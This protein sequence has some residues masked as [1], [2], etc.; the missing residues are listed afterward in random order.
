MKQAE[1][2]P[3]K[4]SVD[5]T[6]NNTAINTSEEINK[7]VADEPEPEIEEIINSSPIT[8]NIQADSTQTNEQV[9]TATTTQQQRQLTDEEKLDAFNWDDM[10]GFFSS[11]NDTKVQTAQANNNDN[12]GISG[13]AASS[14]NNTAS[15]GAQ[16]YSGGGKPTSTTSDTSDL[17]D[18]LNNM[19]QNAAAGGG[20]GS[21][22]G[23]GSN[24]SSEQTNNVTGSVD[25]I[26]WTAAGK[27]RKLLTPEKPDI[28]L[29]KEIQDLIENDLSVTITLTVNE[30]GD[31]SRD[32]ILFS[33]T[34]PWVDVRTYI[35]QYIAS[36]W[37]F[38]S[39]DSPGT[40]TFTYTIKVK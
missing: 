23:T 16:S 12:N 1:A 31:I 40:A 26:N 30:A 22:S 29:P 19:A 34:I 37:R 18:R 17:N 14:S 6:A 9:S 33:R 8:T 7:Y 2:Q 13:S 21:G 20:S 28:P 39:A 4:I 24:S 36:S 38:E 10:E 25:N 15:Q 35:Q 11:S 5:L 27:P 3:E 32:K